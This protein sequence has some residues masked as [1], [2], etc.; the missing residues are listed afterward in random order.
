M[1]ILIKT[2]KPFFKNLPIESSELDTPK[3]DLYLKPKKSYIETL[4][5][6]NGEKALNNWNHKMIER[7]LIQNNLSSFWNL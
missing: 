1:L 4:A 2:V 7:K 6:D 5:G 3:A